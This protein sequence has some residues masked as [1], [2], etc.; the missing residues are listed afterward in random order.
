MEALLI[1]SLHIRDTWT[2]CHFFAASALLVEHALPASPTLTQHFCEFVVLPLLAN[3]INQPHARCA[4]DARMK[5]NQIG[6]EVVDAA[7]KIHYALGPGL[8]E[9]VYEVVLAKELTQRGFAINRQVAVPIVYEDMKFDQG[10]RADILVEGLV[11]LELKSLEQ[12]S[13]AHHKQLLTYLKLKDLRLGYLLNFGCALMKDG[14][15]R[16]VNDL[17][18]EKLSVSA[19]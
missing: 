2:F 18:E 11:L 13:K 15:K 17:P 8:L 9:S 7:V 19:S 12:L 10:Y 1:T 6:K 4:Q 3:K 14:I 5:E 16:I